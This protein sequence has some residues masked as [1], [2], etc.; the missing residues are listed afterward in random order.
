MNIKTVL[1]TSNLY[2]VKSAVIT[3]PRMQFLTCFIFRATV[4]EQ[5]NWNTLSKKCVCNL[6]C[7]ITDGYSRYH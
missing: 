2:R 3:K 5:N 7:V 1:I 6:S 4:S